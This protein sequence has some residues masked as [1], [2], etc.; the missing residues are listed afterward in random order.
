MLTAAARGRI[1]TAGTRET[2]SRPFA[3][4]LRTQKGQPAGRLAL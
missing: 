3:P 2:P 4:A 1:V